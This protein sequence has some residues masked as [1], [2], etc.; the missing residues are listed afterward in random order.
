MTPHSPGPS[1]RSIRGHLIAASIVAGVLVVG[2]AGWARTTELAG[3]V[4]ANGVVVVDSNVKKVQHPTGGLIGEL[5]VGDDQLVQAGEVLVRLDDTQ[6]KAN[7]GVFTTNLDELYARQARQE[8]EKEGADVI[9]FSDDLL[10]REATDPAVAHI[11]EGERKLF[12][13]RS[14]ARAGQKAQLRERASQL[15]EEIDGVVEQIA[16]KTKEIGLIEEELKGV[17]E[18]WQKQLVPYSRVTSLQRDEARLEGERG[19]LIASKA[20]TSGKIAE[21]E[22]QII[23]V[24]QDL[25]SKVA[26]ELS[27]VRAKIAELSE[28][29]IGAEDQLKHVDIRAPQ[30]GR[31]HE[32]TVH[33]VGGV[34]TA[35]ETIMLIVPENDTLSIQARVSP[36]D[37]DQVRPD[38]PV[39]LRFSAFNQR[40]TP[41]L[42]GTINWISPDLTQDQHSNASYYTVR[43]RVSDAEI[44][45]LRG[46][47][48]I[49]GMPVEA[50]IQTGSRTV[51]SYLVKPLTD[52][53]MRS[54][55]EG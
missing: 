1:R 2:L 13:F 48:I 15:R 38:Q 10:A 31:V 34:I 18:L 17:L 19:E 4:I 12:N 40:T 47:K 43:I 33:T 29:K 8:A 37:V 24:D 50:F 52:Q 55:R 54:F 36:N 32:L 49:P 39:V 44:A 42:N 45:R 9:T 16:A 20:S 23:Q 5:R 28:R 30:T 11:L 53:I 6:T 22:L 46:L 25:R 41:Q 51:L 3:A 21:V 27:D 35:G 26:E 7:L 14:E